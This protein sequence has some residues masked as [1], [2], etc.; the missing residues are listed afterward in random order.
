MS[1]VWLHGVLVAALA[2]PLWHLARQREA[3]LAWQGWVMV[4]AAVL[5]ATQL[6]P[7][8]LGQ[9]RLDAVLFGAGCLG[10]GPGD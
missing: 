1:G 3:G 7:M 8:L 2:L 6:N 10:L 4:A 5:L 9:L